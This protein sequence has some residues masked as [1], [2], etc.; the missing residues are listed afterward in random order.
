MPIAR[1]TFESPEFL[2]KANSTT[3]SVFFNKKRTYV[4]RERPRQIIRCY[5]CMKS[6]HI[7]CTCRSETVCER[8]AGGHKGD[9]CSEIVKC[10]NC[11]GSHFASASVCPVYKEVY[12][13]LAIGHILY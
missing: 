8:C 3:L 7:R 10:Y 2:Q 5:N 11:G 1:V 13:S 6:G 4:E 9:D 12:R